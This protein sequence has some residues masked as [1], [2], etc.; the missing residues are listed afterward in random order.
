MGAEGGL[1]ALLNTLNSRE[2]AFIIELMNK[3]PDYW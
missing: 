1:F 2:E 3:D